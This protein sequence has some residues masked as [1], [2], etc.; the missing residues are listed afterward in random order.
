MQWLPEQGVGV[1]LMTNLTYAPTADIVSELLDM[2]HRTGGLE[3]RAAVPAPA[4]VNAVSAVT[5]LIDEW[6]EGAAMD[7]A[8]NNL[9]QDRALDL[10]RRDITELREGLGRCEQGELDA[11]NALRGSFRLTCENG[12]LDVR[13][14]LAPTQPPRVQYLKVSGGR[15]PSAAMLDLTGQLLAS[16]R[17]G[18]VPVDVAA[19][20]D[21]EALGAK[22]K[23]LRSNYGFCSLDRLLEG[24]GKSRSTV[25]LSCDR[26]DVNMTVM[27][28]SNKLSFAGFEHADGQSCVP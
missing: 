5:R 28:E 22:L 21:K 18:L 19:S 6:N 13:L 1:F 23:S 27:L 8:A 25:R 9:R 2:L 14:T 3:K 20:F 4:L 26:G 7:I 11:D 15:T 10:R 16:Q 12:W 24:D 17:S